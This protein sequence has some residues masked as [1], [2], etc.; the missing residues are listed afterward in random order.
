MK[1]DSN[2]SLGCRRNELFA[3]RH[4]LWCGMHETCWSAN[5]SLRRRLSFWACRPTAH[6]AAS[7][8]RGHDVSGKSVSTSVQSLALFGK[9]NNASSSRTEYKDNDVPFIWPNFAHLSRTSKLD[10]PPSYVAA[11]TVSYKRDEENL[12]LHTRATYH[13]RELA[14]RCSC[15][16]RKLELGPPLPRSTLPTR[17]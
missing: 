3:A 12:C 5:Q 7:Q 14:A 1:T 4:E 10:Q 15:L 11:I 9:P 17:A 2:D 6:L 8:P 16:R 13:V